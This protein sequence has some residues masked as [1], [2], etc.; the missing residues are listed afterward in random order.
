[1]EKIK[2]TYLKYINDVSNSRI[3]TCKMVKLAVKR[4]IKDIK[5]SEEGTF[6]YYFDHKKAQAAIIFFS[7]LVHT[8]GKLAGQKL[9]PEPWQQFIIASLYGW[10]RRDNNKRRF[11][12]AYIQIARKNGKSFL[13]AGVSL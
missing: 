2:F 5:A 7:Q 11:R 1:M 6:P 12:R 9:K 13:A 4:H 8:K 3:P 10:R